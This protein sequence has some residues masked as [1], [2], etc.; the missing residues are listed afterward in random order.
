MSSTPDDP[1]RAV[2]SRRGR[3]VFGPAGCT[4]AGDGGG[5]LLITPR[6]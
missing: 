2:G 1:G 5:N 3:R 6:D 4:A